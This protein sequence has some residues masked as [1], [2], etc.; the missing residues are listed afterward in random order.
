MKGQR[1]LMLGDELSCG[2]STAFHGLGRDLLISPDQFM[3]LEAGP[4]HRTKR[5]VTLPTLS[6]QRGS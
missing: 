1:A 2:H 6:I 3:K 4:K 5:K